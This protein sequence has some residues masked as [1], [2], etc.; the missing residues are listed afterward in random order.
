ML[1]ALPLFRKCLTRHDFCFA[2]FW[3]FLIRIMSILRRVSFFVCITPPVHLNR[4]HA[5]NIFCCGFCLSLCVPWLGEAKNAMQGRHSRTQYLPCVVPACIFG[6]LRWHL[7]SCWEA[8][9]PLPVGA[10]VQSEKVSSDG[11]TRGASVA[12]CVN[13]RQLP[14]SVTI[15][16]RLQNQTHDELSTGFV[17]RPL[18]IPA[19]SLTK[20]KTWHLMCAL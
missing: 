16:L 14:S 2:F 20:Q 9:F 19:Y 10:A 5:N 8:S 11:T 3:P 15:P 4:L 1:L 7:S 17:E 12:L 6:Q 18:F 13:P